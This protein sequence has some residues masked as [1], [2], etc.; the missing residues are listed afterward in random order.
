MK[1]IQTALA[2][3]CL[4]GASGAAA[5]DFSITAGATL[6]SRYMSDGLP[7]SKS[8]AFQPFVELEASGFYAGLWASNT[9]LALAG[10]RG[11]LDLYL[12]Y[13]NEVGPL[14]YDLGYTR[15]IYLSPKDNCCGEAHFEMGYAVTDML[16]TGGRLA[17]DPSSKKLNTS[18]TLGLAPVENLSLDATIGQINRGGHRYWSAGGSYA[19][20]DGV[21]ASAAWHDTNIDKG[22]AVFSLDYS[23]NIR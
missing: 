3:L 15:Y 18:A 10:A 12:G 21:S 5:Q 19:F 1:P 14:S 7:L 6:T 20:G 9:S 23:F 13:R 16:N 8:P 2:A 11:E 17:Y 4:V 22:R